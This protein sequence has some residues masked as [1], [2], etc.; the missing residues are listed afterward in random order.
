MRLQ[1]S[2]AALALSGLSVFAQPKVEKGALKHFDKFQSE[3][4]LV[5]P[6]DV[7][8]WLPP[9]YDAKQK[10]PV[11][12]MHDGQMLF[13]ADMTW[14]KLSWEVDN[15]AGKLIESGAIRKFI[16][17]GISNVPDF[18]FSDYFPQKPFESLPKKTQDSIYGLYFGEKQMFNAKV[19]AD[20]YLKFIVNELKPFIDK[21]FPTKTD[22][23]NTYIAGSSMG[24]LISLYA[25]CEYPKTFGGAACLSTHWIGATGVAQ[26]PIPGA[27][28]NYLDKKLPK[29][30]N[31]KIYF[32][33]G[34]EGIDAN[35]GLTQKKVDA[36]LQKHGYK[37]P[38]SFYSKVF[39]GDDHNEKAWSSRLEQPLGFLFGDANSATKKVAPTAKTE[40]PKPVKT[41]TA[42]EAK[43]PAKTAP[44][45]KK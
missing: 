29:A 40:A 43:T 26:N 17:V 42:T 24:G 7:D 13:D 18:R 39:P 9:N 10:Y 28:L 11:L 27:F 33:H 44:A 15:V 12:Y 8:V 16:V 6:R 1:L 45:K 14:N 36:I 41:G 31:H 21:T 19:N 20:N 35:Y 38:T 32:D 25:V 23:A 22:A 3:S 2:I 37:M 30:E 34:T 4:K 5:E